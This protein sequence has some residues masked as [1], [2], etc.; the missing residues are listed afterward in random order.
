[1]FAEGSRGEVATNGRRRVRLVHEQ[2]LTGWDVQS[3]LERLHKLRQ[4]PDLGRSRQGTIEIANDADTD[5]P[6]ILE[7]G[8]GGCRRGEL[9]G[10]ALADLTCC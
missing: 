6:I 10:P 8:T 3:S 4:T 2:N 9:L 5:A 1:M 7:A